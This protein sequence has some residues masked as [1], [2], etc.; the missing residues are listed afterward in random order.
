VR[1][2]SRRGVV[3]ALVV[4]IVAAVC[5][6]LGFW[7]LGRLEDRRAFNTAVAAAMAQPPLEL[8]AEAVAA[9]AVHPRDYLY[10][11]VTALGA[12][13]QRH[14]VLLRGRAYG[15]RPGVHIVTPFRVDATDA[16]ILVNRGWVPSP[17]AATADPRPHRRYGPQRIEGI[18]QWVPDAGAEA[19]PVTIDLGDT[20]VTS[21]RR[22]DHTLLSTSLGVPLPFLYLQELPTSRPTGEFPIPV[23]PPELDEGPHLGYAIQWFSFALIAVGGFVV[24][25]TLK[26]QRRVRG[27]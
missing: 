10:R 7:Q 19:A 4:V 25:L 12:Y 14:E 22:L 1:G 3:A 27:E 6:R 20:A 2:A 21:L 17:D 23:P 5:V 8:T 9:I 18:L 24:V 13:D 26:K 11:S 16:M 15:G